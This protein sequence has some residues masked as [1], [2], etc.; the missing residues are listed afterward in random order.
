M[1]KHTH[2]PTAFDE[3]SK[4]ECRGIALCESVLTITVNKVYISWQWR[5]NGHDGVSND[6]PDDC[7]CSR[8]FR[9]ISKETSK[10]RV[11]GICAGNSPVT[12]EFPAQRTSDAENVSIWWRHHVVGKSK[13]G[14]KMNELEITSWWKKQNK[15]L[16]YANIY[17]HS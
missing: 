15:L 12:G 6:Q 3:N 16:L 5:H 4:Y 10:L 7:L 14:W 8:L 9:R 17:G 11:T 2:G 1:A 13:C